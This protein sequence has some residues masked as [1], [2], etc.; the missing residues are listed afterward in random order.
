MKIEPK[1]KFQSPWL[2][3]WL[4]WEGQVLKGTPNQN[5]TDCTIVVIATY[6]HGEVAYKLEKQ[7][8]LKFMDRPSALPSIIQ[9][10]SLYNFFSQGNVTDYSSGALWNK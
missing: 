2:P 7:F 6:R 9:E 1:C 10:D 4:R 8:T 5:A 3:S